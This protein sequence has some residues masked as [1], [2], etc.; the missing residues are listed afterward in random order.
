M[1][2]KKIVGNV[3]GVPNPK[4]DVYSKDEINIKLSEFENELEKTTSIAKGAN[5]ALSFKNYQEFI[6]C[7]NEYMNSHETND[8]YNIGQNIMIE[9]IDVPDLWVS[10]SFEF[11]DCEFN[12]YTYTSDEAFIE[13]L[14]TN[15]SVH[16][17]WYIFSQ[18]E[19][20]KVDLT[21]YPTTEE[22]NEA[23]DKVRP[24]DYELIKTIEITEDIQTANEDGSTIPLTYNL[25]DNGNPFK[26]DYF[27]IVISC[28]EKPTYSGNWRCDV[29]R[30]PYSILST[31]CNVG[32]NYKVHSERICKGYWQTL[33]MSRFN[34]DVATTNVNFGAVLADVD[35]AEAFV[36]RMNSAPVGTT[37]KI[38]GRRVSE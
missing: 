14:K 11:H 21:E 23:V 7:F 24:N 18:L 26:L 36:F 16:I 32:K 38:Y 8:Y 4:P 34:D 37:V 6:E 27:I 9:T 25:D 17:G 5:Q 2:N 15:G 19:T 28:P 20:Q 35:Y 3:V 10:G 12:P 1:N 22:M 13:E 30:Y 31:Q 29:N 33:R